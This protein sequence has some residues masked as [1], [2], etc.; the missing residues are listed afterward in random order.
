MEG[1]LQECVR[2]DALFS[3]LETALC[4]GIVALYT[5][6]EINLPNTGKQKNYLT[7]TA[8]RNLSLHSF[9]SRKRPFL[10]NQSR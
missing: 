4:R 8:S 1:D 7:S 6:L 3:N 2:K 10:E 9:R 5:P